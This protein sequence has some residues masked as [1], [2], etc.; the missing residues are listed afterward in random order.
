[1]LSAPPGG[2]VL[3]K[4]GRKKGQDQQGPHAL[5]G[6]PPTPPP[7]PQAPRGSILTFIHGDLLPSHHLQLGAPFPLSE[8][9]LKGPCRTKPSLHI[10]TMASLLVISNPAFI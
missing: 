3:V 4:E 5:T 9:L 10:Y 1:M 8:E 7:L 6:R 2:P